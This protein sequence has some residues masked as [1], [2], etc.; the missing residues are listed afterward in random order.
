MNMFLDERLENVEWYGRGPFENYPDR[1]AGALIARYNTTVAKMYVPYVR[2]QHCGN[3]GDTRW[4]ALTDSDG[5]GVLAVGDAPLS[6]TALHFTENDFDAAHHTTDLSPRTDVVLRL[7]NS[8]LGVG[9]GSC[10]PGVLDTYKVQPEP[11]SFGFSLRPL[12]GKTTD[13]GEQ[14]CRIIV[15]PKVTIQLDGDDIL[16]KSPDAGIRYTT[17]GSP[18]TARSP[19]Y[20]NPIAIRSN[21]ELKARAFSA[22]LL[23]GPEVSQQV[24]IPLNLVDQGKADWKVISTDSAQSGEGGDKAIDGSRNTLWHT[25]WGDN[26]TEHPHEL[27]IDLAKSYTISGFT[28]LPRSDG[29]NGSIKAYELYLSSNGQ[30]WGEPV[31]S[32]ELPASAKHCTVRFEQNAKGRYV[33]LIALSAHSGPWTSLA[34]FDLLTVKP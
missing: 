16:L 19:L 17:D 14:A 3:R 34:E 6:F 9:N 10:G 18:V 32:G 28:A 31:S 7:N 29:N 22:N 27:V 25:P 23:P 4:V 1:L 30:D 26:V 13:I 15:A 2:P 21:F 12:R 24:W 20:K 11:V 33:K 5:N 8:E